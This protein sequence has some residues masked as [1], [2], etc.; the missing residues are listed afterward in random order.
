MAEVR[1]LAKIIAVTV[2]I[3]LIGFTI[4][5]Y[6]IPLAAFQPPDNVVVKEYQATI[7]LNGTLVEDYLY[8]IRVSDRYRMLYRSWKAPVSQIEIDQPYVEVVSV[9]APAETVDYI[10]DHVGNVSAP[11]NPSDLLQYTEKG[12]LAHFH[13]YI[14]YLASSNEVGCYKKDYFKAGTYKIRYVFRLHPPIEYDGTLCHLNIKLADEHLPYQ[15]VTILIENSEL[16]RNVYQHPPSLQIFQG[17][18]IEIHGSSAR[19]ELLE[20]EL[21]LE[22]DILEILDGFVSN[23]P[24]VESE[25]VQANT[26]YV[27][28]YLVIEGLRSA[29]KILVLALPF[30]LLVI[31]FW[32]NKEKDVTVPKYLSYVPNPDRKP[33]LVNL[34]FK[35]DSLKFDKNGFYATILDLHR[36]GKIKIIPRDKGLR[37]GIIDKENPDEMSYESKVL[38]FLR[39]LSKE[40]ILDTDEMKASIKAQKQARS[41]EDSS[42]ATY[43]LSAFS[44][45]ADEKKKIIS[46]QIVGKKRVALLW[47][48]PVLLLGVSVVLMATLQ[49]HAL[50]PRVEALAG[51][52]VLLI[53]CTAISVIAPLTLFFAKWREPLRKEKLEW[54]SFKAVLSDLAMIQRYAPEDLSIWKEWLIYGTALGVGKKV[55]EAMKELKIPMVEAD[56]VYLMPLVFASIAGMVPGSAHPV[57]GGGFG[58]G[59]GGVR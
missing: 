10:K 40:N 53:Q 31:Y 24:N 39:S 6:F 55:A 45:V 51:S 22:S 1:Q 42:S 19:N 56:I 11:I 36:Q 58:G 43:A 50:V 9:E 14:D 35:D 4:V 44:I 27:N 5:H 57:W 41:L 7:Y 49:Y 20:V 29:V 21:L 12:L 38:S 28:Q 16:V 2:L 23:I 47:L 17:S 30:I 34:L 25:T 33:W 18:T 3:G 15:K 26:A 37:I 48:F 59:G 13:S 8:D 54:K 52:I 32:H 46:K